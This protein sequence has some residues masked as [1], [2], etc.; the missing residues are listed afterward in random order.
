MRLLAVMT[1]L[2]VGGTERQLAALLPGLA[3]RGHDVHLAVFR[4]GGA[5]EALF[6]VDGVTRH[7]LGQTGR[8]QL[9]EPLWRLR[10]LAGSLRPEVIHPF[11][12]LTNLLVSGL[13]PVL[14]RAKLVCGI[15][16]AG[17]E[18]PPVPPVRRWLSR[19]E[20]LCR[21]AADLVV[22]NGL[23]GLRRLE[24][25]GA[26]VAK[27]AVVPNGTDTR[28]F[29]PA[30][31]RRDAMRA[32]WGLAT[33]RP[34]FG[35]IARIDPVKDIASFLRAA[36][37]VRAGLPDAGF[38]LVGD[39]P[40]AWRDP[41]LAEA[42]RLGL[43]GAMRFV[44]H[45]ADIVGACAAFDVAVHSA[46]LEGFPNAIA[47]AMACG[48]PVVT[49]DCGDAAYLVGDTGEVVPPGD[50]AALAAAMLAMAHRAVQSP[51]LGAAAR[52]RIAT[53][54][55]TARMLDRYGRVL[56]VLVEEGGR[57]AARASRAWRPLDV[58]EGRG[59]G[60]VTCDAS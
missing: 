37:L 56:E 17:P 9:L 10:R 12:P 22:C 59:T 38:V 60:R 40:P 52:A 26:D 55:S 44:G 33:A 58:T 27:I 28:H 49:S 30:P 18:V 11:L 4:R 20:P 51:T 34:V 29:A 57:A 24:R 5:S 48:L 54:F 8:G 2:N 25:L 45:Q 3:A 42:E 46:T 43:G 50:P 14:P 35:M 7:D 36:A 53:A 47:E 32:A 31:E 6:A 41:L 19:G 15:R 23:A 21:F 13:R 39:G 16:N 1:G